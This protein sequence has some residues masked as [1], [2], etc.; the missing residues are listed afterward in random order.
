MAIDTLIVDTLEDEN[1]GIDVGG[2]S[3][4]DAL[5]TIDPDGTIIFADSLASGTITLSNG[6]LIID[7]AVTLDG[8]SNNITIDAVGQSRVLNVND[9]EESIIT[10][11]ISG[12]TV[13]GGNVSGVEQGGGIANSENLSLTNSTVSGNSSESY[14]GGIVNATSSTLNLTDSTITGNSAGISGGGVYNATSSTLSLTDI[15]VTSNYASLFG[16]GILN[17]TSSTS[18]LTDSTITGNSAVISGGGIVNIGSS[19]LNLG[20]STIS[21]NSATGA[22]G[23]G[24]G[25]FNGNSTLTL[26]N[27]TISGNSASVS[28]GGIVNTG[29]SI[30]NLGNSTISG[31]SASVSGGGIFNYSDSTTNLTSTIVG[32]NTASLNPDINPDGAIAA[33][34]SL[35]QMGNGTI[36]DGVDGNIIG[37]D[38]LLDPNG[39][40]D[41]GGPTQTIALQ[42]GSPAIDAGS[43]PNG[44][45]TDQRGQEFPRVVGAAAD[46]GAFEVMDSLEPPG[47][48]PVDGIPP[49]NTTPVFTSADAVEVLEGTTAVLTVSATDADDDVL[50]F[51]I[52]GGADQDAF[53]IDPVTNLLTFQA[54]PDFEAPSDAN[55]DNVFEVEVS[56]ADEFNDPVVQTITVSVIDDLTNEPVT[57]ADLNVDGSDEIVPSVDVLN[58]FRVLAGAPQAIVVPEG[59]DIS[60]Q[61]I[62]DAVN[63]LGLALDV[64]GSG[65]VVPSVDVLNIFRVLAGAPQ[66]V[67]VPEGLNVSQQ[68]ITDAVNALVT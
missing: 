33:T 46:I 14:G 8:G 13:S 27:S 49:V 9:G 56:V 51:T 39:L 43:N 63:T 64:D 17:A 50:E 36:S 26:N 47:N 4:R 61:D 67:V 42:P 11:F 37:L 35:I 55:G 5:T 62:T 38:P 34:D 25:I 19:I 32:G 28:G 60:Q 66:A 29:S 24:G 22:Y 40:Q 48:G 45:V 68:D 52:N 1:N 2:V 23:F 53:V 65:E 20:N 58:I 54:A 57:D 18:N 44:L 16:G 15:I 30:L 3:L 41:N 21:G 31:N 6:E 12:L 59:L 10:V 7:R